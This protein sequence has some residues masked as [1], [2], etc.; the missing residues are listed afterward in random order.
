MQIPVSR[1][2][3][4]MKGFLKVLVLATAATVA[5]GQFGPSNQGNGNSFGFGNNNQG[6]NNQGNNNSGNNNQGN[7][8]YGNWSSQNGPGSQGF[9]YGQKQ[10]W[11]MSNFTSGGLVDVIVQFKKS[12][13]LGDLAA[14]QAF[15]NSSDQQQAGNDNQ[16]QHNLNAINAFHLKVPSWAIPMISAMPNVQYVSPVRPVQKS[17]DI[18]DATVAA[19]IAWSSGYTGSG[20]GVAIIDS[21]IYSQDADFVNASGKSRVVYSE[22]FVSGLDASDQYGHG[23]HVAGIVGSD[24]SNSSGNGFTRTFKGIAPGVNLINLRV[25]D[26]NGAG[27]DA[28][29]IAAI[30]R[31]IQLKN[32]YNIRVINLSLGRPVYESYTLDPLCQAVEAAWQAGIVVVTA[33]GNSG[34]DNSLGTNGYGTII[35]PGN[36]PYVI[37]VGAMN[38]KG[39]TYRWDDQIASYSSKGPTLIDHIVK[40]DLVAPGNNIVSILAPNST[41]ATQYPQTLVPNNYYESGLVLG[42]SKTYLRLSGTSMATPVV[43]GAAALLIQQNP[44]ISPDQVKARLMKTAGKSLPLYTT[45]FDLFSLLSFSNQSDIFTVGAGYLDLNAALKS[46]DLVDLPAVSP[47]A[48]IDTASGHITIQR[49]GNSVWGTLDS[50]VWG[51][52]IVWGDSLLSGVAVN[53]LSIVWGDT[54]VNANCI[55]WGDTILNMAPPQA[56]SASDGD[57]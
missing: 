51:D 5:Y 28:N 26:A 43:S 25:L 40:P 27:T 32:A 35:A 17:L 18:T 36:D 13:S 1:A 30:Q 29:V 46:T 48:V 42:N 56:L 39:T 50:I 54:V 14:V 20:V 22:S 23:T 6:S 15:W 38:T 57:Q 55:V 49:G 31:A 16:G 53:G 34:R 19:N 2:E 7:S 47:T 12:H 10:S 33:A 52:M 37:T 3:N 21:G 11:D 24:G 9:S 41:L 4:T 8:G 45:A 44:S